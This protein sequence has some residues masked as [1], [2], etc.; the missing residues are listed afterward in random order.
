M[1]LVQSHRLLLSGNKWLVFIAIG[2][3]IA[4]CSPKIQQATTT[5]APVQKQAPELAPKVT[6]IPKVAPAHIPVVSLILPFELDKVD[7]TS[8]AN[9]ANLSQ[10]DLAVDYYQALNWLWI[11]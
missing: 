8:N 3:V 1:T 6:V 9:T 4:A 10:S 11:H 5:Q 2:L 7:L